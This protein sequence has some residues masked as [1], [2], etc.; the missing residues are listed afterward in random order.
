MVASRQLRPLAAVIVAAAPV[1]VAVA[2]VSCGGGGSPLIATD[3]GLC[4]ACAENG[5]CG[6]LR[7][8]R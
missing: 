2:A 1:L 8:R 7:L 5:I 3:P 6:E 4:A